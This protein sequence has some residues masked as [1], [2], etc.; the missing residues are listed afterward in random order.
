MPHGHIFVVASSS[1]RLLVYLFLLSGRSRS[2]TQNHSSAFSPSP[3]GPADTFSFQ[4]LPSTP[5]ISPSASINSEK[6]RDQLLAACTPCFA[7]TSL[8]PLCY[9]SCKFHTRRATCARLSQSLHY[10]IEGKCYR[11]YVHPVDLLTLWYKLVLKGVAD[12]YP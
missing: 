3:L 10:N 12:L 11:C 9:N 2:P 6:I 8:Y 5:R 4:N 1:S 7:L